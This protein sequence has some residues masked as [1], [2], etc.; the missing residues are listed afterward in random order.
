MERR[1]FASRRCL[2]RSSSSSS[3]RTRRRSPSRSGSPPASAVGL[4]IG[5]CLY[6]SMAP[7]RSSSSRAVSASAGVVVAT[8]STAWS[9]PVAAMW[10]WASSSC[11]PLQTSLKNRATLSWKVLAGASAS[12]RCWV[13]RVSRVASCGLASAKPAARSCVA[14]NSASE[15]LVN[16]PTTVRTMLNE[17]KVCR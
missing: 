6:T 2:V 9:G 16:K 12:S 10:A 14:A 15:A 13:C 3:S 4:T 17:G 5:R 1:L 7:L 8:V 11:V